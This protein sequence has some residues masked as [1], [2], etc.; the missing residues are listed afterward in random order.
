MTTKEPGYVYILTNPSFREDWVKIGKSTNMEKRLKTLNTTA[1][2]LPFKVYATIKTSKYE[3][4]EKIIHKQIDRL[5]DLRINQ[6]REF[7]N[8]HPAQALDIFLDQATALD[9]AIVTKYENGKPRQIYPVLE[10]A[11][12][13]KEKKPQ[14]PP[15]D[16]SMVG[17]N[18]GDKIIFDALNLE[19]KVAGRNKVE[20][21]GRLWSLSAFCGT[22]L[23]ENMHNASEAYQGPKYFSYQGKTLWEI[24]L[25][26]ETK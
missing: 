14:R 16:F 19:V 21:E 5:T 23:P 25:E 22:Y 7:F 26:K 15:F 18:V 8:V 24:R 12:E 4:L 10:K 13:E 1:L 3:E 6:S 17:L 20:Y 2:P 9:D 11:K